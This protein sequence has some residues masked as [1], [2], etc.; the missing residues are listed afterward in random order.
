MSDRAALANVDWSTFLRALAEEVDGVGGP[1]ARD[2]LL[3][4]IG[5]RMAAMR[6][7][8]TAPNMETLAMELNDALATFGWGS[9]GFQLN[10][11]DRSLLITHTGLPRIGAA[12]DPPGTWISAVLEGLYEGWMAQLPGS[13]PSLVARRMR[14]TAQTVLLRYGRPAVA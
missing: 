1:T 5:W 4:R 6:P 10:E 9:V 2:A 14:V 13:D 11:T 3:R 7:L 8:T 12:G